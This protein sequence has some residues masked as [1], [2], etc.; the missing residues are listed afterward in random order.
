MPVPSAD[1]HFPLGHVIVNGDDGHQI[2]LYFPLDLRGEGVT[3]YWHGTVGKDQLVS[4]LR[5]AEQAWRTKSGTPKETLYLYGETKETFKF[6]KQ[7]VP[8]GA[9]NLKAKAFD[10]CR[11]ELCSPKGK[12]I[13]WANVIPDQAEPSLEYISE[14]IG[15][16]FPPEKFDSS[17]RT[18]VA[19][20]LQ[21]TLSISKEAADRILGKVH[22]QLHKTL[23]FA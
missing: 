15:L 21:Q 1:S 16:A 7:D 10:A 3:V 19:H 6:P 18:V 5:V 9:A 20:A 13:L 11:I 22:R 23:N 2:G 8:E 4:T 17:A 14:N 12:L